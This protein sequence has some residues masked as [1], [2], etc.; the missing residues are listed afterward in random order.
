MITVANLNQ[1]FI[2]IDS[3]FRPII[4]DGN[5]LITDTCISS[6]CPGH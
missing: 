1:Q 3:V 6:L 5:Y 4:V 2:N